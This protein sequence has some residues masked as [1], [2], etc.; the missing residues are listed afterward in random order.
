MTIVETQPPNVDRRPGL[1]GPFCASVE[2]AFAFNVEWAVRR[3][4]LA[5]G[6]GRGL[7]KGTI[8]KAV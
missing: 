7:F 6:G 3:S 8:H 5:S 1:M 4:F 2:A